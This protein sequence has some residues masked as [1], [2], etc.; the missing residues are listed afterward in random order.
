MNT[1]EDKRMVTL[2]FLF[3]IARIGHILEKH[4]HFLIHD[5]PLSSQL[6]YT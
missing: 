5:H 6:V 3:K 2:D 1:K 4:I